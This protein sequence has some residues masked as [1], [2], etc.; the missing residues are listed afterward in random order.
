MELVYLVWEREEEFP[1]FW[2]GMEFVYL[3]WEREGE[4][5]EEDEEDEVREMVSV[6]SSN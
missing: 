2:E 5:R 6:H 1:L 4:E 3:M